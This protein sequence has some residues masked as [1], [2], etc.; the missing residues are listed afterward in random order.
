MK[1]ILVYVELHV[2][3]NSLVSDMEAIIDTTLN[4]LQT[5]A[6]ISTIFTEMG[7]K[8]MPLPT[9]MNSYVTMVIINFSEKQNLSQAINVNFYCVCEQ[10]K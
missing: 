4:N 5:A 10:T 1:Y 3:H 6:V 2:I 8:R 7:N 9:W